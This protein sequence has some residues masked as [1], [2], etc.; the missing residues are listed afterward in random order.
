MNTIITAGGEYEPAKLILNT[1]PA[2]GETNAAALIVDNLGTCRPD[3]FAL[4]HSR[5]AIALV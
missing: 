1:N 5:T 3:R 2:H 4:V